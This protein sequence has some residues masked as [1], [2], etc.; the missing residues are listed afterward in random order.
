MPIDPP[1]KNPG[2]PQKITSQGQ[3]DLWDYNL[4]NHK[5][6]PEAIRK[7]E[8]LRSAAK[9]M[10]HAI[11]EI[12]PPG[13]DQALALTSNEQMLFHANAAVARAMNEGID[14]TPEEDKALKNQNQ[15]NK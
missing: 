13:R 4:T 14:D 12:C 2:Q 1:A 6:T 11:I 9:A 5:P 15:E 8:S 7:I 10:A 3:K